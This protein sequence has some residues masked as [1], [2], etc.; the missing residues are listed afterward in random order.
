MNKK[1]ILIY[2]K[3]PKGGTG[4]FIKNLCFILTTNNYEVQFISHNSFSL[5]LIKESKIGFWVNKQNS[6]SLKKILYSLLNIVSLM[7]EIIIFK[8]SYI[9]SLDLYA[10]VVSIVLK[11][12]FY[13]NIILIISTHVNLYEHIYSGRN[14]LFSLF[15]LS[16]IKWLYPKANLHVAPSLELTINIKKIINSDHF[17]TKTIPYP[18]DRREIVRLSKKIKNKNKYTLTTFSRLNE[19]K[20]VDLLIESIIFFNKIHDE[21]ISLQIVGDGELKKSIQTKYILNK[22][23]KFVGWQTNPFPYLITA[24]IFILISKYEGFPFSL[25]EAMTLGKPV[26]SSDV[27]YGPREIIGKNEFGLLTKNT[28]KN[29]SK[30]IS[31]MLIRKNLNF[32]KKQSVIRAKDF[33]RAKLSNQYLSLFNN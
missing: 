19:Q 8:P 9:Y 16:I 33:D 32:Y 26:I 24:K 27:N 23:I 25:L 1:K 10:N 29:I 31:I 5:D 3:D 22:D 13:P 11:M 4:T 7:R 21:K 30:A 18:I 14:K 15:L 2:I 12:F 28:I 6:F 20:N 17:I